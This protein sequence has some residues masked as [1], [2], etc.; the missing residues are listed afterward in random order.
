MAE[1]LEQLEEVKECVSRPTTVADPS[2]TLIK[3]LQYL[4]QKKQL[5]IESTREIVSEPESHKRLCFQKFQDDKRRHII[6]YEEIYLN[7]ERPV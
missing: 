3:R 4:E 7:W 5:I 6:I 1:R 2:H